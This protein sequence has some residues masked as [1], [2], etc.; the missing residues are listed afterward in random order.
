M[1]LIASRAFKFE[2][3]AGSV[4]K[5]DDTTAL[6]AFKADAAAVG[7]GAGA[8]ATSASPPLA[9]PFASAALGG[10]GWVNN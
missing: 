10:G 5:L 6:L 1:A 4:L 8:P 2:T 7:A 9:V 3:A